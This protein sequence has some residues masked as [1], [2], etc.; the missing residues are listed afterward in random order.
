LIYTAV[1]DDSADVSGGVAFTL[2]DSGAG[3]SIDSVTGAVTT[4]ADFAADYEDAAEQSFTVVATDTSGFS[5][6]KTV[7]FVVDNLDETSPNVTSGDVSDS[8]DENSGAGQVIYTA[9]AT[10]GDDVSGGV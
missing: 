6:E 3:L 5:S 4:N 7:T 2:A 10:D 1:A 9:T 8:I